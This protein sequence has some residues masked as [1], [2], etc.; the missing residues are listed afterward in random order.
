V[1]RELPALAQELD[2]LLRLHSEYP[3]DD[4][5]RRLL[6]ALH[7]GQTIESVLLPKG[8]LCVST[9]LGCA[10]GCTFCMTGQAGLL[11]QLGSAEIAAQVVLARRLRSVRKVV[12]MGMGEPAHNLENV[13]VAIDL[14]ANFGGIGH[15]N[16]VLSTVGDQRLFARLLAR[17]VGEVRPALAVSLH[18]SFSYRRRQLLPRAPQLEI[19]DL[20]AASETYARAS[21]YPTQYQW[22]LLAGINDGAA[23]IDGIVALLRGKYAVLNLIPYNENPGLTYRRPDDAA[24]HAMLRQL[25]QRGI[26]TKLRNSV[27]QEIDGG[28]GQLRSRTPAAQ[29]AGA[30]AS[31]A[32]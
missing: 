32:V 24:M 21:G 22:T 3:A 7:D 23:E 2:R 17:R 28:C 20:V 30:A 13:L 4:G 31:G 15:K 18:S 27:G 12:L 5:A 29:L 25:M 16:L 8:G 9:Q 1:R 10:V 11:R 19:A 26:L 6:L 14:L